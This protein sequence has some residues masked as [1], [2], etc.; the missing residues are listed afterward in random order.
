MVLNTSDDLPDPEMPVNTV[1][2]RLGMSTLTSFRLFTRAPWTRMR[3]WRSAGCRLAEV[4]TSSI[5]NLRRGLQPGT[6]RGADSD[7]EP[8]QLT[9]NRFDTGY[10]STYYLSMTDITAGAPIL[11]LLEAC[12][13]CDGA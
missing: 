13:G 7:R 2:R 10:L 6:L 3:S 11:S 4:M 9:S 12:H 1:S 5:D 8:C